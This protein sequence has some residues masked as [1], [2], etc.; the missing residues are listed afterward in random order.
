MLPDHG[1]VASCA[2]RSQIRSQ[3]GG[4]HAS[5]LSQSSRAQSALHYGVLAIHI[6][7]SAWCLVACSGAQVI[8]TCINFLIEAWHRLIQLRLAL[9]HKLV[10]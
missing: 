10:L 8:Q 7:V 1:T 9:L 6:S 5:V 3:A 4:M 2:C